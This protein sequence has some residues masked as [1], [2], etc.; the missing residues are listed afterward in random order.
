MIKSYS[1]LPIKAS[2]NVS[3]RVTACR[4]QVCR[5]GIDSLWWWLCFRMP[6]GAWTWC[7]VIAL[8]T[9]GPLPL[10]LL[11]IHGNP[12]FWHRLCLD[13]KY[14]RSNQP[15]AL[16]WP[17]KHKL[18]QDWRQ[19]TFTCS[20]DQLPDAIGE[21]FA[22]STCKFQ[23]NCSQ[24][25]FLWLDSQKSCRALQGL[26]LILSHEQIQTLVMRS[27]VYFSLTPS[28]SKFGNSRKGALFA[29]LFHSVWDR[30]RIKASWLHLQGA[31]PQ[32]EAVSWQKPC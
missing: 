4:R 5:P 31:L 32:W 24:H 7:A 20:E 8:A 28:T 25:S 19:N 14:H 17:L 21:A 10:Q 18:R 1:L 26:A 30:H 15:M 13:K 3:Q 11:E 23:D 27:E 29:F 22:T 9:S 6:L 12:T 16:W 2:V